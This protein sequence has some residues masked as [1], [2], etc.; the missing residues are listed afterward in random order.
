MELAIAAW[1]G[2][3]AGIVPAAAASADPVDHPSVMQADDAA[4]R[5]AP[6]ALP[7]AVAGPHTRITRAP[8]VAGRAASPTF[9]SAGLTHEVFGFA[10]Y[11]ELANGDLSDAQLDR[12]S[13]VAYFGLTVN[14]SGG[15]DNDGGMTGWNSQALT[16]LVSR[17]RSHGDR[18]Q[19]VAKQFDLATINAIVANPAVGQTAISNIISAA[20]SKSLDGVNIDF[21]GSVSSSYPNIQQDFSNWIARL[22][23]QLRAAIPGAQLTVDAYSGSASWSGG[24]MNIATLAPSVDAFFIMAYDMNWGATLPNAPLAG[25]YTYTD[26]SSIDQ[27]LAKVNGDGS[28]VILGVPYYGYKFS[29]TGTAFNSPVNGSAVNGCNTNCAVT[30]SGV[31]DDFACA[32]QLARHFDSQSQTPWAS[33]WSPAVNDPCAGNHNSNREVYYDDAASIGAKYDLVVNRN[34]RG[35]GIWALGYDHGHGE[36]W[37]VIAAKYMAAPP[38]PAGTYR[39]VTPARLFD[40]RNSSPVG[41]GGSFEIQVTGQQGVPASGVS[42]A[43]INLTATNVSAGGYLSVYPGGY[44]RPATSSLNT[45]RGKTTTNLVSVEVGS[46]G[47]IRVFNAVGVADVIADIE[48]YISTDSSGPAGLFT[49]VS[50]S[51]VVDTR[52]G[53][54]GT[55]LGPGQTLTVKVAGSR[56]V[57]GA[58]TGIPGS[59][60][61]AVAV[62][63]TA[64]GATAPTFLTA[65][66]T[67]PAVSR[68]LASNLNPLPGQTVPNR[69]VVKVGPNGE[70]S[71]YNDAGYIDV[72]VDV[73]GWF[74]DTSA[75][76]ATTGRFFGISPT[77]LFD[78]RQTA[79]LGPGRTL[80]LQVAG[81]GGIPAM[82]ATTPPRAVVLNATVTSPTA[83]S[84]LTAYPSGSSS[85][86]LTSDLNFLPGQTVANLVIVQLG[87]DGRV[88][89]YNSAGTTDLVLDIAAW[90]S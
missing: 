17:A 58:S 23:Q 73:N 39:P 12:L 59:G 71:I 52:S 54:G 81:E 7:A 66:P 45:A 64:T 11:Y 56:S 90:I 63:L 26:S 1:A 33:W 31:L 20:R 43:V 9:N 67:D 55:R 65:Y 89:F 2:G 76:A 24:F 18:I 80:S 49:P 8:S 6:L 35:S 88:N 10:T 87:P 40:T 86:P 13:T 62:N 29:T 50:P 69:A 15:F 47:T 84:F 3:T 38:A 32:P 14:G 16:D 27:Y 41:P 21:E 61:G 5:Y 60:V 83:P 34:I 85:P 57:G 53:A 19:L 36:L 79:P 82:S 78:T 72:L 51:R 22:S 37:D 44:G 77:R 42:G 46:S 75:P 30:Y 28:K 4:H 70:I 68:P 48:G 25:Q 74:S